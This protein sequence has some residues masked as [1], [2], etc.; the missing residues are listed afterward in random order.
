MATDAG[1]FR[2]APLMPAPVTAP[3]EQVPVPG[4]APALA[5]PPVAV[6]EEEAD[7]K[8][9]VPVAEEEKE[10]GE[11]A[12]EDA[13][14]ADGEEKERDEDEDEEDKEAE[15]KPEPKP[16]HEPEPET[17]PAVASAYIEPEMPKAELVPMTPYLSDLAELITENL[18]PFCVSLHL[19]VRERS[20]QL[21]TILEIMS[22]A[23]EETPGEGVAI[24]EQFAVVLSEEVQPVSVK[25]QRKVEPPPSLLLT[26]PLAK[27]WDSLLVSSGDEDSDDEDAGAKGRRR[28]AR[29]VARRTRTRMSRIYSPSKRARSR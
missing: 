9:E 25:A 10:D 29:R 6:A 27:E 3:F 12:G 21:Q 5:A 26:A 20:C 1:Q 13:E 24:M 22:A 2:P 7:E 14:M 16:E 4:S 18:N 19:E 17:E 15:V 23:E 11:K 28:R 8:K